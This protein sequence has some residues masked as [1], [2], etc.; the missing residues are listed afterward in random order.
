MRKTLVIL[1][2]ILSLTG[3]ALAAR[4]LTARERT[5]LAH[6]VVNAQAWWDHANDASNIGDPERVLAKKVAAHG[7]A[8]DRAVFVADS[9]GTAY[10]SRA[11]RDSAA[12]A[13]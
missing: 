6:V 3:A 8:Y 13:R 4:A 11:Q 2:I 9:T 1:V 5:V 12:A 10:L 7:P